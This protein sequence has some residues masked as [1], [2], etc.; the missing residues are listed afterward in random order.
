LTL[1]RGPWS[2]WSLH[3]S[4]WRPPPPSSSASP[5]PRSSAAA[6][7]RATPPEAT[8]CCNAA[9]L[10]AHELA[11]HLSPSLLALP[12]HATPLCHPT[13]LPSCRRRPP[14]LTTAVALLV[15]P[16]AL[17]APIRRLQAGRRPSSSPLAFSHTLHVAL[18]L[19]E[20]CLVAT[21]PPS[22]L[23]PVRA[24]PIFLCWSKTFNGSL[25]LNFALSCTLIS[26]RASNP[27]SLLE[28]FSGDLPAHRG[29]TT[30]APPNPRQPPP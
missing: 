20:L 4:P 22:W 13:E 16:P 17:V 14:P 5:L 9:P 12:K 2:F 15:P 21:S 10:V 23:A 19:P 26:P 30:T 27:P 29:Q 7:R 1:H 28:F 11:H 24:S 8:S 6:G 25:S 18:P 3:L